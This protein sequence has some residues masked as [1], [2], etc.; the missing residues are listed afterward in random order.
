M[1]AQP[2]TLTP[3]VTIY[4]KPGCVQCVS[5]KNVITKRGTTPTYVDVMDD[6]DALAYVVAEGVQQ[7]PYV[8]IAMPNGEHVTFTGNRRDIIDT[9]FPAGLS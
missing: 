1:T 8:V 2:E 4:G 5:V 9:Y 6:A 7:M 3:A